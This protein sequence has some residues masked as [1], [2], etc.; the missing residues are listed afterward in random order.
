[1][2][3]LSDDGA[4]RGG[5]VMGERQPDPG[6]IMK[7]LAELWYTERG[8]NVECTYKYKESA[9]APLPRERAQ[10]K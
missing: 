9:P 6:K 5:N 1:M 3:P 8:C 2:V 7:I 10:V 4:Y